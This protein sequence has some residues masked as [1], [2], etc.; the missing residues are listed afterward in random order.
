MSSSIQSYSFLLGLQY[1]TVHTVHYKR[2]LT[3]G[4]CGSWNPHCLLLTKEWVIARS[5]DC[6]DES[7]LF[8]KFPQGRFMLIPPLCF[9]SCSDQL[10]SLIFI[11]TDSSG[12]HFV[13]FSDVPANPSLHYLLLA[14]MWT[15]HHCACFNSFLTQFWLLLHC[16][17]LGSPPK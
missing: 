14:V 7:V 3:E 2:K 13:Y 15:M 9:C 12:R 4:P 6:R 11:L 5:S 1:I 17:F 8:S 16:C 10:V